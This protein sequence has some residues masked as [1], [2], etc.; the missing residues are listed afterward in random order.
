MGRAKLNLCRHNFGHCKNDCLD[1]LKVKQNEQIWFILIR[2][3]YFVEKYDECLKYAKEALV[4]YPNSIKIKELA[5]KCEVELA[6]EKETMRQ[7]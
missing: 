7:I 4:K 1:A 6:K 5:A 2:S 3:R